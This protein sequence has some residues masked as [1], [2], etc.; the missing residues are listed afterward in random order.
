MPNLK[1]K[2]KNERRLHYKIFRRRLQLPQ[3]SVQPAAEIPAQTQLGAAAKNDPPVAM[4]PGLQF[5]NAIDIDQPGAVNARELARVELRG[6][7]G[8]SFAHQR[9]LFSEVDADVIALGL[10][11]VNLVGLEHE[12][13]VVVFD[14]QTVEVLRLVLDFGEQA[15]DPPVHV[16]AVFFS[17][18]LF[19][20]PQ[21]P[22]EPRAVE[23]L[24]QVIYSLRVESLHGVLLVSRDEDEQRTSPVAQRFGNSQAVH[25]RHLH[26]KKDKVRCEFA[27]G[28]EGFV[29]VRAFADDDDF[30]VA[31]E[32]LAQALARQRLVVDD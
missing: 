6:K 26:V 16:V 2:M 28:R 13:P 30:G 15:E 22:R 12:D 18:P 31:L 5:L 32:Q 3:E 24:E 23:R 4:R 19:R 27:R 20:P 7:A 25:S 1:W 17:K 11:P 9:R 21:S 14:D 8:E 10:D 29:A